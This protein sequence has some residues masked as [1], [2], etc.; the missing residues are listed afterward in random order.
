MQIFGEKINLLSLFP[1]FF[2]MSDDLNFEVT[3][4]AIDSRKV[5][6]GDLFFAYQG[7]KLDGRKFIDQA[8]SNGAVAIACDGEVLK[9]ELYQNKTPV[10][11][12]PNLPTKIGE[13]AAKFYRY[14]SKKLKVIGITGTNGKTSCSQFIARAL[15]SNQQLCGVIGTLGLGFPDKLN[16]NPN[17]TPDPITLQLQFCDFLQA[18]ASAVAMEVSSQGIMQNRV[19]GVDFHT[20]V[21]T[22]LTRDH[23]D[24]HGNMENYGQAKKRL[25]LRPEL[26]NAV[27]NADDAFGLSLIHDL[28]A[29]LKVYAYTTKNAALNVPTIC[30][31]NI[32]LQTSGI[33]A[34]VVTPWGSGKLHSKLFGRFN[35]SNLLAVLGVLGVMQINFADI[36][37]SLSQL[38]T[39]PGRMQ[40]FGGSGGKP[41]VVVDYAHTPEALAAALSSLREHCHGKLWCVFGCGGERDTGKRPLMGKIAEQYSDQV[42]ITNDNPRSEDPDKIIADIMAGLLCQKHVKVVPDRYQA[43]KLAITGAAKE[44]V[45]L[46]AGKGHENYQIIGDEKILFSDSDVACK[47]LNLP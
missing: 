33:T 28:A 39:V 13:I 15:S 8:I 38:K 27:I 7:A 21:F 29:K 35:L 36:L 23:L 6:S 25:F 45:I 42:I 3:G 16:L 31:T 41:L 20:A 9:A 43:I 26:Q 10:L 22:N 19:V 32:Q 30:A 12:I 37:F 11:V 1:E 47:L 46:L 5:K 34:E 2:G 18:G 4:L 24:Y 44:D 40:T 17:T 14:P